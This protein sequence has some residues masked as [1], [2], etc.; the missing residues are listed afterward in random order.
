M[1]E[2]YATPPWPPDPAWK[3]RDCRYEPPFDADDNVMF[4]ASSPDYLAHRPQ[5]ECDDD[6]PHKIEAC[7]WFSKE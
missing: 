1:S 7:R 2:S 3:Q 5:P 6:M 4:F